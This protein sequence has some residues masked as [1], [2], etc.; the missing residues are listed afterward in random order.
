M[1]RVIYQMASALPAIPSPGGVTLADL[2]FR[3]G[4]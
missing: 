2:A 1:L 4:C 3:S